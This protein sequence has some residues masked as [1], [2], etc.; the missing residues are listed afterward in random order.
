[1]TPV[2]GGFVCHSA[3]VQGRLFRGIMS[4]ESKHLHSRTK[5]TK[6][7]SFADISA[8]C[9]IIR[10]GG[11]VNVQLLLRGTHACISCARCM[12]RDASV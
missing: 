2:S 8:V 7:P 3:R 6:S 9:H 10:V 11:S 4:V 12:Q 5:L 1:M